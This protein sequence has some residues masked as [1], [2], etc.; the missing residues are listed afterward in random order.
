MIQLNKIYFDGKGYMQKCIELNDPQDPDL[1]KICS[2]LNFTP[3]DSISFENYHPQTFC[4]ITVGNYYIQGVSIE[5][6]FTDISKKTNE[7]FYLN[8]EPTPDPGGLY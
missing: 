5:H 3:V 6:L 1:V 7:N 8:C 4:N 2:R